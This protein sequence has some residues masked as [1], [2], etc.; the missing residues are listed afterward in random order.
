MWSG[1]RLTKIQTTTRPYYA[2]PEV[3]TK[4]GKAAQNREKQERAKEK[5]K[6]D[7]ARQ[8]RGIYCIDPDDS[9]CSDFLKNARRK[10]ERLMEPAMPCKRMF[11]SS[12]TKVM[13]SNGNKKEFK[14]NVWL[15]SGISWIHETATRT[16]CSPKFMKIALQETEL[17]LWHI[18]ICCTSL[19]TNHKR[20]RFRMQ[21]LPWT[22][23][24]KTRDC[25]SMEFG[26]SQEQEGAY[27]GSTKRQQQGP[28]CHIDGHMSPQKWGVGTKTTEVQRQSRA[29]GRTLSNT[30]LEPTH[31]YWTGL[32]CV[33]GDCRNNHGC[34]WKIKRLWRTSSWCSIC[35]FSG[36]IGGCSQIA[37][38]SQIGMS[39][40]LA[41]SSTTQ[42]AKMMG[43]RWRLCDTSWTK[44][45]RSPISWI[46]MGDTT[47]RSFVRTWMG[48][49]SELGMY[50]RSSETRVV[51]VSICGWPQKWLERSR[52]WIP[53]GRNWKHADID[54][55]TSFLDHVYLG[56]TQ[57]ECKP[58]ETIIEKYTK[59]FG[60]RISAGA[61]EKLP[62]WQKLHAQTG[63]WS[64]DMEGHAQKCVERY[65]ELAN[66]K[67]VQLYKV[68][69]PCLDDHQLKQEELESVGELSVVCSRIVLKW[70]YLTRIGRL[71]ILW[72]VNKLARSVSKWIQACDKRLASLISY[73]HHTNDCRQYCHVRTTAQH[74]RLAL[75][76]DTQTL[77]ATLRTQN[78][79]QVVSCVFFFFF[80][81]R[82]FVPVCWMCKEQSSV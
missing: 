50:V 43:K 78:Q 51:S 34:H 3:W 53:C 7:N 66:K 81:S 70:S 18:T 45:G 71:D 9:E 67:V 40:C 28:L 77:L 61:T 59:M 75:F 6:L 17:L 63:A 27:S 22:R 76:Q 1:E 74:G 44:L 21:K 41:T 57:R 69:H 62:G 31:F 79:P 65:C 26:E 72:S 73:I 42:M 37:E 16:F 19:F 38:N 11:H 5:L 46:A 13:Q 29:L 52:T 4:I 56:C 60:S 47:W 49:N 15:Y 36:K 12:V 23:N 32:V 20:W 8:L 14:N 10:L 54:E 33:P 24:G 68:S 39:R 82:T 80:G 58:N 55:R 30:T 48:G 64:Y 2:W 25:P 35:L